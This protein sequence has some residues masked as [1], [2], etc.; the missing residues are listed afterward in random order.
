[1]AFHDAITGFI[2]KWCLWNKC[3]NSVL[4][5]CQYPDLVVLL[6][7]WSKLSANQTLSTQIWVMKGHQSGIFVLISQTSFCRETSRGVVKCWLFSQ[8]V[9]RKGGNVYMNVFLTVSITYL[10]NTVTSLLWPLFSAGYTFP[11]KKKPL[12]WSPVNMPMAHFEIPNNGISY[13]FTPSIRPL[14]WNLKKF[15]F[16][17]YLWHVNFID[18][19]LWACSCTVFRLQYT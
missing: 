14:V 15:N 2:A 11:Y 8:A 17:N 19:V 7:G 12:M 18:L 6:I 13:N 4:T 3:R 16:L 10:S 1:M 5:T 9:I